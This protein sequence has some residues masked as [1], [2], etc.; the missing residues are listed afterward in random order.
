MLKNLKLQKICYEHYCQKWLK[1][2]TS[3]YRENFNHNHELILQKRR[4]KF[5]ERSIEKQHRF[6]DDSKNSAEK[7]NGLLCRMNSTWAFRLMNSR[8]YPNFGRNIGITNNSRAIIVLQ[9]KVRIAHGI[10]LS[11][12]QNFLKSLLSL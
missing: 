2:N 5:Y 3:I 9:S 12:R 6:I 1:T 8:Y 11:D 10:I 4:K 7:Y